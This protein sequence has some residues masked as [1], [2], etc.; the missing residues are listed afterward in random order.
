VSSFQDYYQ[1][2][3]VQ[4]TASADEIKRAYR[5]LAKE[6]HPDRHP[7]QERD[8]VEQ[9]FKAIA[10]AHE[11]LSDPQKRERYDALG[12]NWRHG[13]EFRGAGGVD[14]EQFANMF[15]GAGGMGGGGFSDFF[16]QMFGDMFAGGRPGRGPGRAPQRGADAEAEVELSVGEALLGGKR[17]L[18][19]RTRVACDA[20][21]GGGRLTAGVCPGCGGLGATNQQ[22]EIELK[23]PDDVRDGQ[24][25]RLRGLGRPG[26][27]GPGDLRLTLRLVDDDGFRSR[28]RGDVEADVEVAPWDVLEGTAVD[29]AVRGGTATARVPAGTRAGQKLR[30]RG[31]GLQRKDGGRGDL[32]LVVRMALPAELTD[33]QRDLLQQLAA[34]SRTASGDAASPES[35]D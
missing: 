29:V 21:G 6:W 11:V 8:Q 33:A 32:V 16:A 35:D 26:A 4:R 31:Q 12:A 10:E 23:I 30:L 24:V 1:T 9:K 3:G 15:G 27:A 19:F 20:C 13:Q 2:L 34:V 14:P 18:T 22:K 5:K 7:E 25:L 28:G 17:S